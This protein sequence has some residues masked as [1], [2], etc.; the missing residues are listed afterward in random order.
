MLAIAVI[1]Q[2]PPLLLSVPAGP[3]QLETIGYSKEVVTEVS[4]T[5]YP[6]TGF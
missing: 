2:Q 5:D 6:L 4:H 1:L 3:S